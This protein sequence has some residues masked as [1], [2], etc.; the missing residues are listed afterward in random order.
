MV[1][2]DAIARTGLSIEVFVLDTGRLHADTLE[3]IPK[4]RSYYGI[5][6]L[7]HRPNGAAL[8]EYERQHGRDAFYDSVELRKRCCEIRK[9]EPLKL[10]L[11]GVEKKKR[12][13]AQAEAWTQSLVRAQCPP[14]IAALK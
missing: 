14:E 1:L 3:L 5:N 6:V 11:A 7:V 10:A 9:V 8:M 12:L 13:Q 2:T 4:I